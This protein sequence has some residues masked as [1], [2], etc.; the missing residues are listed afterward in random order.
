MPQPLPQ[1]Q[2]QANTNNR[3]AALDP[4]DLPD[5]NTQPQRSK[6]TSAPKPTPQEIR[7]ATQQ[8]DRLTRLLDGLTSQE[9]PVSLEGPGGLHDPARVLMSLWKT[10]RES[11]LLE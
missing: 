8:L 6:K 2:P 11:K 4:G 5:T 3:F 1:P 10:H 7:A 9:N